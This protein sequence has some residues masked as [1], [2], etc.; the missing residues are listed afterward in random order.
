MMDGKLAQKYRADFSS[1]KRL[2]EGALKI[3]FSTDGIKSI[4]DLEDEV[5]F[6]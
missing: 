6:W 4:H 3:N 2:I 5:E 1:G